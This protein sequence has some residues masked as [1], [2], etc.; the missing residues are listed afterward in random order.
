[1]WKVTVVTELTY[2]PGIYLEGLRKITQHRGEVIL[3]PA[4]DINTGLLEYE[5]GVLTIRTW[6]H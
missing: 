2:C 6:I 3:S 4:R 5:A 1:M